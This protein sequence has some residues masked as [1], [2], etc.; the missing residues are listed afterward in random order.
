VLKGVAGTNGTNGVNGTNGTNG[1]PGANGA[2]WLNGNGTPLIGD[3]AVGD[4]YLDVGAS[5]YYGPKTASGWGTGTVLKGTAGTNGTNGVNGTN[6]INGTRWLSGTGTPDYTLGVLGDFYIDLLASEYFGP[7]S[8]AGWGMG[9]ALTGASGS[10]GDKGERGDKGDV[11]PEG[12]QGTP[13]Q[14]AVRVLP[15]G[16]ISMGAFTNGPLPSDNN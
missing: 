6:G 11:G 13:G 10:P 8:A 4:F 16:D 5:A 15:M 12:P 7:K 14:P 9:A 1:A 3:G 2:T